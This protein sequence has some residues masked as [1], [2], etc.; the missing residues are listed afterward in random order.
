MSTRIPQA[1]I[2]ELTARTDIVEVIGARVQLK[3]A[4]KIYKGLCPFHEEKTPSFT[5]EPTKGFYHCFGCGAHDTAIGFLMNYDNLGFVEAVEELADKL[6]LEMPSSEVS[7]DPDQDDKYNL[8]RILGEADQIYRKALRENQ[9]AIKYLQKRGI[10]GAA[11][12]RFA[13]GYAPEGWDTVLKALAQNEEQ[14]DALI[15][16]GLVIENEAGRRYDRFRDRVMFPIRDQRGRVIGFGGR[17]LGKGEPKYMNSPETPVFHKGRAL[18]GLHEARQHPG[19]AREIVVVEGYLDVVSLAQ[20][21]IEPAVATLGTATTTDHIR[22]LTRL[23]DRVIFCFDGDRAGRAAAWRAAENALPHAGGQVELVF[24]LMPEGEDPDSL[25]RLKGAEV[26]K[27]LLSDALPLSSFLVRELVAQVELGN[28]DGRSKLAALAK[29]VLGKISEG[30]YRELLV[31]Q[32][33]E[34]IGITQDR[35]EALVLAEKVRPLPARP[36]PSIKHGRPS[37]VRQAIGLLLHFPGTAGQVEPVEDLEKVNQPGIG[38]LI[39]ILEIAGD[40]PQINTGGLLERFRED[41]N[42]RHLGELAKEPALD[43]AEAAPRV[44]VDSLG[45]IVAN[46]RKERL[47]LLL[48]RRSELNED[49]EAELKTLLRTPEKKADDEAP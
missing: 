49:E 28:V 31:G 40:N 14:V 5:V 12:G 17:V 8:F 46:H 4:G 39:R 3:K 20:H 37:L 16:A 32:L 47:S 23:S 45:R 13:I 38:L 6:G 2:D 9:T 36:A 22:Q 35:F 19:R 30:V 10:D 25:V 1:F 21:G 29:P 41:P 11:A 26:F 42:G 24:L 7:P 34:K 18:Y 33:A 27:K 15:K 43:D 44:L 48:G